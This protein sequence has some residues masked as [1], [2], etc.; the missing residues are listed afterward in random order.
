MKLSKTMPARTKTIHF[1][2]CKKN[3]TT[4]SQRYR[5]I[6]LRYRDGKGGFKCGWCRHEFKDGD[7]MGLAQPT[8]GKNMVLCQS[9]CKELENTN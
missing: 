2:W 8:R 9:C 7:L 6:R 1:N 5:D 3:F 4:M